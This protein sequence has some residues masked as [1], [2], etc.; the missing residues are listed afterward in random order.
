MRFSP[1]SQSEHVRDDSMMFSAVYYFSHPRR[2][3]NST[4]SPP[5]TPHIREALNMD[6]QPTSSLY[7]DLLSPADIGALSYMSG[8]DV[9]HQSSISEG[10]KCSH[11]VV[12]FSEYANAVSA[13]SCC[14]PSELSNY[15]V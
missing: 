1:F 14:F 6:N 10:S 15:I 2:T 7:S 9:G 8:A 13:T 3:D 5:S 4:P 11:S 12:P